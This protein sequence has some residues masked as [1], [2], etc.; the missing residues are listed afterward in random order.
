MLT[1]ERDELVAA[2][3]LSAASDAERVQ[4]I[5]DGALLAAQQVQDKRLDLLEEG[6]EVSTSDV[7]FDAL[8]IFAFESGL[9]GK[10]A[11]LFA[12]TA[13][14]PLLRR[15]G[16]AVLLPPRSV[17][18]EYLDIYAYAQRNF[19]A[20]AAQQV[21]ARNPVTRSTLSAYH[22]WMRAV[23]RV[24]PISDAIVGLA[25][26]AKE[27]QD[28]NAPSLNKSDSVG[29]AVLKAAQAYGSAHRD[30]SAWSLYHLELAA[31][32][33]DQRT[34]EILENSAEAL[35]VPIDAI[36]ARD[37]YA[38]LYEAIIWAKLFQ[39]T[40]GLKIAISR[41]RLGF[42]GVDSPLVEYWLQR[43]EAP[44]DRWLADVQ[45]PGI[46]FRR[47]SGRPRNTRISNLNR[48]FVQLARDLPRI[49]PEVWTNNS[50]LPK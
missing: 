19:G 26:V 36:V 6:P 12:R 25:H 17:R 23:S 16:A 44:I 4:A 45:D 32:D 21:R 50:V 5:V 13:I 18:R 47:T 40:D 14:S 37:E 48:F 20:L 3:R 39:L 38:L 35:P 24:G 10:A 11:A 15:A 1:S 27:H 41:G 29:V 28:V 9:V 22:T 46:S 7:L 2:A 49:P 31:A 42:D 30:A 33:A 43:F 8:V 34:L